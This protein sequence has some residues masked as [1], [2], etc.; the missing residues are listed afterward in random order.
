MPLRSRLIVVALLTF[1]F[2]AP[3]TPTT[4]EAGDVESCEVHNFSCEAQSSDW[5]SDGGAATVMLRFPGAYQCTGTLVNNALS[6]GRPFI[7]T[8]R[9]CAGSVTDDELPQVAAT[10]EIT[11]RYENGCPSEINNKAVTTGALH[12]STVGDLWLIEALDAPPLAAEVFYAGFDARSQAGTGVTVHHGHGM[13]KEV[14]H[15]EI[16]GGDLILLDGERV[17]PIW[18]TRM[19]SGRTMHGSSGS[20]LLNVDGSV[21]GVLSSGVGC[22]EY[23]DENGFA[24]IGEGWRAGT[25]PAISLSYWLDPRGEGAIAVYGLSA[26]EMRK[27]AHAPVVLGSAQT[28]QGAS[29]G[30]GSMG[31][32]LLVIG[33]ISVCVRRGLGADRRWSE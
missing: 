24:Q 1:Q 22:G 20:A 26:D 9:H 30:G 31:L 33:W 27:G 16:E 5:V 18:R 17:V 6:D 7:I 10:A 19:L 13:A 23:G 21:I 14:L 8:A 15:S 3:F 32:L 12:R 25:E 11:Y 4:A 29:A 28:G 2:A